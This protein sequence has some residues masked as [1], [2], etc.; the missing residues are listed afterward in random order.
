MWSAMYQI[1]NELVH[2]KDAIRDLIN[3]EDYEGAITLINFS[4]ELWAKC[5]YGYKTRELRQLVKDAAQ[6]NLNISEHW[7][8]QEKWQK[9]LTKVTSQ[10][11][12]I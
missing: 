8:T 5:G 4:E 2:Q 10:L 6:H 9:M 7:K 3:N 12:S 11:V 1:E